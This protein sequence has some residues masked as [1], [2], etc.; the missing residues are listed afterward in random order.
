MTTTSEKTHIGFLGDESGS[1][2]GNQQAM[3]DGFN[4]FIGKLRGDVKDKDVEITLGFFDL[5][6]DP[7]ILRVR[8]DGK[9]NDCRELTLS[10][11]RP[12]GSTPLND[13]TLQ[14]I[15]KLEQKSSDGE[16]VMLVIFTDGME[17]ASEASTSD[18]RK[19]IAKKEQQG[20]EFLY[21]GANQ[22][23]WN[24]GTQRGV[25][26][27]RSFNTVATPAGMRAT[28]DV[29]A[30]AASSYSMLSS[31][32]YKNEADELHA[33]TKGHIKEKT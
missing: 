12:R 26:P 11:Y 19:I 2:S 9:L 27:Q 5:G 33:R 8:I 25:S 21:L 30:G 20:W 24:E 32:D 3:V 28:M 23:A 29:V 10:D 17:N 31:E 18:V 6:S 14:M 22:D 7:D 4:D 16:K 13:A 15:R 1:M